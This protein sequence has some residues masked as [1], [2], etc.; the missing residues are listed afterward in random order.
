MS[1]L[2]NSWNANN[3][4]RTRIIRLI[5]IDKINDDKEVENI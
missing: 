4:L 5:D 3:D 2:N 1:V